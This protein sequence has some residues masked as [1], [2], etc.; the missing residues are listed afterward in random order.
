MGS[1]RTPG[2]DPPKSLRRDAQRNRDAVL[3]AA[4]DAFA[5]HGLD[6]PL[7]QVARNAGVAIGTL[8]RH[9][10]TRLD[11]IEAAFTAKLRAWI[12]AGERAAGAPDPW[13]G[14]REYLEAMCELQAD[15]RG[16]SDLASMRL[17]LS[18]DVESQL[19]QIYELGKTIME[20]AQEQG[21]VRADL[22]PQDYAF[23]F[24]SHSRVAA[25]TQGV[26]PDTWRRSL[27][28]LLDA[29][30]AEAAHPLPAPALTEPQLR[31]A[32]RDLSSAG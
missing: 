24:W 29:F 19:A 10:P 1:T 5:R 12:A 23:V 22:R 7:E 30:R 16:L 27:A 26:A 15:D 17:P 18:D 20:R 21:T 25:A 2:G 3:A 4:S 31:Q 11:L 8:Y 32:M 9:F 28:L 13:A 6:V 14:F